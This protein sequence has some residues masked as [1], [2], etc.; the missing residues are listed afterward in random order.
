M[1][2]PAIATEIGGAILGIGSDAIASGRNERA[3]KRVM[4]QQLN[5]QLTLNEQNR[6]TQIQMWKDT[7]YGP[8]VEEM[9]AAGI[10]PGLL[11]GMS[12]GG[13]A[14]TTG[15]AGGSAAGGSVSGQN[16]AMQGMGMALQMQLLHAQ[17]ENIEADTA[18]KTVEADV[19]G[20][21]N[22]QKTM[23]EASTIAQD[24]L[25]KEAQTRIANIQGDIN[26]ATY[27]AQV[28]KIKA[29]AIGQILTNGLTKSNIQ[30]ND[31]T[32]NK[33]AQDIAQGWRKLSIEQFKAEIE[34]NFK[35]IS[36][37]GG[38]VVEE[39]YNG[40]KNIL[41]IQSDQKPLKVGK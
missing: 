41:G 32:I 25:L 37:I 22:M 27:Q 11:Y 13:G 26:A 21:V 23:Q 39:L 8:Q 29:D 15:S 18:K 17:K 9:K 12:G 38:N 10:N 28:D 5:N 16:T 7:N 20:G 3:Q 24:R 40:I 31:A 14:T 30:I 35:D 19:I 33:M 36:K 1:P 34:A 4:K 6:K 2:L